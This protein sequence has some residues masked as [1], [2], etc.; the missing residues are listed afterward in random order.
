[1]TDNSVSAHQKKFTLE[2]L[3]LYKFL[4]FFSSCSRLLVC[5]GPS[6]NIKA[7]LNFV[8]VAI[9]VVAFGKDLLFWTQYY[10]VLVYDNL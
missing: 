2:L 6:Y 4:E 5:L 7:C 8:V 10:C 9:A 1:M 3:K